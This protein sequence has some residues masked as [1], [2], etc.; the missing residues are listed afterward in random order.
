[1]CALSDHDLYILILIVLLKPHKRLMLSQKWSKARERER[2]NDAAAATAVD[3]DIIQPQHQPFIHP[4][5]SEIICYWFPSC[6]SD[7]A[8]KGLRHAAYSIALFRNLRTGGWGPYKSTQRA[9]INIDFVRTYLYRIQKI[10]GEIY[11]TLNSHCCTLLSE[12]GHGGEFLF[13]WCVLSRFHWLHQLK[14][15]RCMCGGI[16]P[17]NLSMPLVLHDMQISIG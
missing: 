17:K 3:D 12:K 5:R 9:L 2:E 8:T 11:I 15:K 7:D 13:C 16:W 10:M 14:K 4:H 1:M 6:T